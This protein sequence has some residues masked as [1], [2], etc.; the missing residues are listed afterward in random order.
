M[1]DEFG[2]SPEHQLAEVAV[3]LTRA[4]RI[5]AKHQGLLPAA[6]L[7]TPAELAGVSLNHVAVDRLDLI[8]ATIEFIK[9]EL[10]A[11]PKW[12]ESGY[13]AHSNLITLLSYGAEVADDPALD[14]QCQRDT[15]IWE[16][17]ATSAFNVAIATSAATAV[18]MDDDLTLGWL[19]GHVNDYLARQR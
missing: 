2:R 19:G 9:P 4:I 18:T 10:G 6:M 15:K 17:Y 13:A 3:I 1:T 14:A 11:V 5:R 8:M 16:S 7:A 12:G